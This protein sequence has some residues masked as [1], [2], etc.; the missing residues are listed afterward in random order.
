EITIQTLL[1]I[2]AFLRGHNGHFPALEAR[3]AADHGGIIS[4]T[5]IAMNFTEVGED[6]LNVIQRIRTHGVTRQLRALPSGQL[7][8]HLALEGCD[9]LLCR[10]QLALNVL[11]ISG[12]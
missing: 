11:V 4:K 12:R 5:A 6:T 2:A 3:H 8:G 1:G 7:S 9:A 10:L